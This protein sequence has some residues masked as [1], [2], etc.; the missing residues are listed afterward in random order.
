MSDLI[1]DPE[2][3]RRYDIAGPRYTSYPTALNFHAFTPADHRRAVE[4]AN[5]AAPDA[6]LSL[7]VHAP[8]CADPCFYCGCT[9]VITR[10]AA[11]IAR[12]VEAL[13]REIEL[14]AAL[15][16]HRR[17]VEQLHFGGGTP[18]YFSDEQLQRVLDQIERCF[19]YVA[20]QR[21]EF[22]VEIDPRTVDAPRLARLAALGFNRISL[23]VQDF[24]PEVQET[25]NR[26][27]APELTE[28]LIKSARQLG[29]RSVSF[30]LIYGLPRQSVEGFSRTLDR[31]IA[32]QPDRIAI[33]GYAHLPTLFK[34]Q[35]Q[36]PTDTLPDAGTRLR[37]LQLAVSKLAAVGY[38][39]IGMDHFARP[40][41]ELAQAREQRRLQRNFQGYS[42]RAG[43]DLV[44]VGM[45]SIGRLGGAYT[46]NARNLGEYLQAIGNGELATRRGI[47]LSQED[48]LR[49]AVIERILCGRAVRY[50]ELSARFGVDVPR[51]FGTAL[52]T[53]AQAQRDGLVQLLPDRLVVTPLGRYFLRA[54]AMPFDAYLGPVRREDRSATPMSRAV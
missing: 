30:D 35:R 21:R 45:S 23:G 52:A 40:G 14:Q 47:V 28:A 2:L 36:I 24:D 20:E 5:A 10:D 4:R 9:R 32:L 46:Q 22:S 26:V 25:I 42:T 51:H 6:P 12:Y 17:P 15:F 48:Q 33:Y 8:F 43:L 7:Y 31:V 3:L 27:Q 38:V 53:L 1:P 49:A 54:L 37:L 39:H 44:G 19:G 50:A 11:L 34:A 29:L 16:G 18:T 13:L 41:D